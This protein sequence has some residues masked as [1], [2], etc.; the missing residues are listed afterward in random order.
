MTIPQIPLSKIDGMVNL[1]F[2]RRAK[3]R[4]LIFGACWQDCSEWCEIFV[5][6][7]NFHADR[8]P[9]LF[10]AHQHCKMESQEMDKRNSKT[11]G[12]FGMEEK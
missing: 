11:Y 2:E 8:S 6:N 4:H 9:R 12:Y 1:N 3:E 5:E 7:Q 10:G